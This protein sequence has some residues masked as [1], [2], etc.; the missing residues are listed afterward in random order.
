MEHQPTPR[1]RTR[2]R[3]RAQPHVDRIFATYDLDRSGLF[4]RDEFLDMLDGYRKTLRQV[5]RK[6]RYMASAATRGEFVPPPRG[7]LRLTF[8]NL[9]KADDAEWAEV[10]GVVVV[11]M[12]T[13]RWYPYQGH[14]LVFHLST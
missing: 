14:R 6:R 4:E 2:A 12:T 7:A 8:R 13:R 9:R 1:P 5:T 11:A 10:W 3:A